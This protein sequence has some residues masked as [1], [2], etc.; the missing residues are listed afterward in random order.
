MYIFLNSPLHISKLTE[1]AQSVKTL[2]RVEAEG[3]KR[4]LKGLT[5]IFWYSFQ[6]RGKHI[7]KTL[8]TNPTCCLCPA[9]GCAPWGNGTAPRAA[10]T[11][12][13]DAGGEELSCAASQTGSLDSTTSK[14]RVTCA[15]NSDCP[16]CDS[17]LFMCS[18]L[19]VQPASLEDMTRIK[20]WKKFQ[21]ISQ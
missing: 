5:A 19:S 9:Q 11:S 21:S 4:D 16:L 15:S 13:G 18:A 6:S 14:A 17:S 12:S 3:R 7:T 20:W 8:I 1:I 10:D 2:Y